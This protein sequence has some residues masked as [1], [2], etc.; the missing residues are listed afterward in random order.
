MSC[1]MLAASAALVLSFAL[2]PAIA[3]QNT[4]NNWP[5]QSCG[6]SSAGKCYIAHRNDGPSRCLPDGSDG[7]A[8]SGVCS[9]TSIPVGSSFGG[10]ILR[11]MGTQGTSG[12]GGL[13]AK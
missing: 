11:S 5:S 8:C 6:C 10:W 1:R 9:F 7:N 2:Q 4:G 13:I 12:G 3:A